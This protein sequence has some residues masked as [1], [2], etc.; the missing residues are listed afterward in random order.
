MEVTV[1]P[2]VGCNGLPLPTRIGRARARRARQHARRYAAAH[3]L[4]TDRI[5]A[6]RS[7]ICSKVHGAEIAQLDVPRR[8]WVEQSMLARHLATIAADRGVHV[9]CRWCLDQPR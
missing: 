5:E 7:A 8:V 9:E 2:S 3:R 1:N 4:P 6:R